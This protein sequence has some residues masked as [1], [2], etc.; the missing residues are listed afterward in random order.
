M[1]FSAVMFD[2]DG[3]LTESGIGIR[4]SFEYALEKLFPGKKWDEKLFSGIIGPPLSY[5]FSKTFG[6]DEETTEKAIALYRERFSTVGIF[7]NR[8][9]DGVEEMLKSLKEAGLEIALATSKPEEYALRILK[10]FGIDGYFSFAGGATMGP[11][12]NAKT[13][14][15]RY[16]L[17][18]CRQKDKSKIV[19][20]GDKHHDLESSETIGVDCIG[21]LYGY[22][23]LEELSACKNVFLAKTP[24]EVSDFIL[25]S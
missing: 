25:N 17:E 5:S 21:V 2:L 20:V 19:M 4:K 9:Y 6:F 18:N 13:D 7:E 22:G 15:M 24:K 16:V 10:H 14:V 23:S 1:K 8:P 12:R 11:E 3:T